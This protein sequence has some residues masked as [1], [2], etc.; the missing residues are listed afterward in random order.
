[1]ETDNQEETKKMDA[2]IKGMPA[3][4]ESKLRE[5]GIKNS[6]SF[7]AA[8]ATPKARQEL[9]KA[10]G[11]PTA[12]ILEFANRADLARINGIGVVF[13][14]LLEEAG[15]DTIKELSKRVPQNLQQKL[16]AVNDEKKV[17]TRVPTLEILEY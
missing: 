6:D 10:I 5:R 15:V 12:D 11:L 1:M 7:L 8:A 14:D 4:V 3:E 2:M 17:S 16:V 13:A 9:A